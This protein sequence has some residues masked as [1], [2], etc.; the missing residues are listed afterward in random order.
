LEIRLKRNRIF[1]HFVFGI[2][3]VLLFVS[4]CQEKS[5]QQPSDGRKE[6]GKPEPAK[7][8]HPEVLR[9]IEQTVKQAGG[10]IER[11]ASGTI[12]GVNLA[13]GRVSV[14]DEILQQALLIPN[15]K[16]FSVVGSRLSPQAFS[17]L[18]NQPKLETLFLQDVPLD[19]RELD[20]MISLVPALRRLTLRRLNRVGESGM[21]SAL[22]DLQLQSLAL[23]EMSPTRPILEKIAESPGLTALDLRFCSNL[24]KDDYALLGVMKQLTDLKIGGFAV[25]DSVLEIM[26]TLQ[27]LRGLSIEGSSISGNG[28]AELASHEAWAAQLE[29]LVLNRNTAVY[30]AGLASLCSFHGLKRLTVSDMMVNGDFLQALA[31]TESIRTQLET[32]SL[33]KTYLTAE[34]AGIL[35][36]FPNL[37]KLDLSHNL[38]TPDLLETIAGLDA[39]ESLNLTGCRLEETA[40]EPIR[41]MKSLKTLIID[42]AR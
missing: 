13:A 32:L 3:F 40:L 17:G 27:N 16:S 21:M 14:T 26:P 6:T 42:S 8:E 37:K 38:I 36:R 4:G 39:L 15:L 23:I 10:K 25:D 31:E 18:K 30:D 20:E 1:S 41:R 2:F 12:I 35:T 28:L 24:T 7:V 5:S 9:K 11:D 29:L 33:P 19:D 22:R 34:N